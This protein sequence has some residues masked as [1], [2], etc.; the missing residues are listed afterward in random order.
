MVEESLKDKVLVCKDCKQRFLFTIKEQELY[1]QKD[2][3]D[4]VRC[5]VCRRMKKILE[6]ALKDGV[7]VGDEIKFSEV[8]D[9][10]GRKFYT[11]VKRRSGVN[12][13]CDDCWVEIKHGEIKDRKKNT[14]LD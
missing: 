3:K 6:L 1:G 12:L 7:P 11:K 13:Y 10:C 5:R 4:P 14:G 2:W 8:C 9:K